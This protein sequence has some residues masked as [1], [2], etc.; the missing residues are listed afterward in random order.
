VPLALA[1]AGRWRSFAVAAATVAILA[2]AASLAFGIDIW[3]AFTADMAVARR[4]W[5]E[6]ANPQ[7]L[8]Y[9]STVYGAV[10][11]HGG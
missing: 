5:L 4:D 8:Q 9:L 3:P 10:R 6:P 11:L 2:A 7:Y 1:V